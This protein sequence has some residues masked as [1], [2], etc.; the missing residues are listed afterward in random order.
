MNTATQIKNL[1]YHDMSFAE[2]DSVREKIISGEIELLVNQSE[3]LLYL[4]SMDAIYKWRLKWI[5]NLS[6]VA[7]VAA[8]L[9][10]FINWHVSIALFPISIVAGMFVN[11]N[12]P[13][14]IIANC[15]KDRV[16]LKF[17]L[18]VGLVSIR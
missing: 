3:T 9:F 14:Y 7:L 13:K 2:I 18:S 10:L 6:I 8:I 16:F 1:K 5:Q 12:A 15:K 11:L 17:A 4:N